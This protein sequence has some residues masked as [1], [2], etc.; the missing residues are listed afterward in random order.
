VDSGNR[1]IRQV[2]PAAGPATALSATS[3][4][5]NLA[6]ASSTAT[7]QTFVITN[8]GQGT[9]NW[10]AAATT[11][12]GGAWLSVSPASGSV[13]AGQ[14]GTTAT[15]TANPASLSAGDYYG[16]IQVTS[17]SAA[18]HVQIVTVRLTVG[19]A[20]EAPP[21]VAVGGVL[22]AASFSLQTPVAPGSLVSI[23]GSGFTDS[24]STLVATAYPWPSALGTTT[25]T[26]GGE[27]APLYVVTAGQIN[28]M[29]PFDLPVNTSLPVVV[30]RGNALS[31]PQ[32]VSIVSA[33]PGVFTQTANGE[34]VG[35]VVI[36]NSDGSEIEVGAAIS[37]KAGDVLA[38]YCTG[39]GDV[40]PTE[41]AGFPAS[42]L[43]LSQAIDTVRLTIGGVNAQVLF[44]GPTPGFIGL[45]QVNAIV[46][47][48]INPS[49]QVPLVL[50]QGGRTSA[51]VTMPLQ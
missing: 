33:Q 9:L 27:T 35:A 2:Q 26:V 45:Y 21:Q 37:A 5:F 11:T 44:A 51:T 19:T 49:Q 41:V 16:K 48:G 23:F 3:V 7:T 32:P 31:A 20:G 10:A 22:N 40:S 12:S 4:T 8:G 29:L 18:S 1:R 46:P 6:A 15:V 24:A 28:A 43:P 34:G 36:V 13:V 30:T 14:P 25:V 42:P 47:S 50:S 39:L 38:I 17:P